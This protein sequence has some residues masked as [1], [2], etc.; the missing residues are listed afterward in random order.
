MDTKVNVHEAKKHLSKLLQRVINSESFII[1]KGSNEIFLSAASAWEIAI[2]V[3]KGRLT[4]PEPPDQYLAD[5]MR[6]HRFSALPIELGHA[7]EVNRLPDIH[8]DP[9]T[10]LL[11]AQSQLE[12]IPLLTT[13]PKIHRY[14]VEAIW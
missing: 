14:Q 6:L 2:E 11:I 7:L 10:R 4:L 1:A 8:Q 9:F 13:D 5:R 3:A 12:D